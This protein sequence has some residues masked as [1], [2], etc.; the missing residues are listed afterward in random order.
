VTK[1]DQYRRKD[2]FTSANGKFEIR[3]KD[4]EWK[5][6]EKASGLERYRF[7]DYRDEAIWF[8]TMTMV[9]SDDGNSV[10]AI[11]DYSTQKW[12]RNPDVLYFF[13]DGKILKTHSRNDLINPRFVS[14]S[15]S[16]FL[17]T[18]LDEISPAPS[19]LTLLTY[20]LNRLTF[21]LA[22]GSLIKKEPDASLSGGGVFVFGYIN[23]LDGDRH[24]FF[25]QGVI[26]GPAKKGQKIPF[27]SRTPRW[28]GGGLGEALVI[29]D[30]K[31]I[32]RRQGVIFNVCSESEKWLN[33]RG[34]D[35]LKP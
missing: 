9:V 20:E 25:V 7:S 35:T 8:H 16:H 28:P 6:I 1:A 21:D 22:T 29:K 27:E 15:V 18:F 33:S 26:Q 17:W 12:K 3:L 13:K 24:M 19:Q 30:G 14:Y 5:L 23:Y 2:L 4:N 10:I 11:D 34:R 32:G 31:L